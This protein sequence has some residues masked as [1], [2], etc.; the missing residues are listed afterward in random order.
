MIALPVDAGA[1]VTA[2]TVVAVVEA[3]KMEHSLTAA[4]DGVVD[5][6]VSVGD[7]VKVGDVLAHVRPEGV[8]T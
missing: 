4:V 8:Q 1:T 7:Q 2:G 3:M 5:V 6:V